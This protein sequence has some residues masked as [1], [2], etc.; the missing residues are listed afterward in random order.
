M[1]SGHTIAVEHLFRLLAEQTTEVALLLLD[2]EGRIR[3][4]SPGA[5][6]IFGYSA[7]Q[8]IGEHVSKLFTPED[9][10]SGVPEHEIAV[11]MSGDAAEDDRWMARAEGARFWASGVLVALRDE[12]GEVVGF[13][14][15]LRNRT[16][17][18]EHLDTLKNR[19]QAASD[20]SRRKDVFISTLVHEL[21]APLAPMTIAVELLR[22][23]QTLPAELEGPIGVLQRQIHEMR[24][25]IEKMLE[26]S[27]VQ[28]GKLRLETERLA[29]QDVVRQA[30]EGMLVIARQKNQR[31]DVVLSGTPIMIEVD[32][33]RMR[34]VFVNLF[35]NAIRY[36]PE[37]GRIW[38]SDGI[39]GDEAVLHVRDTG[40]GIPPEMLPRIFDLFTQAEPSHT[41]KYTG[42]GLG[43]GLA[44]VKE[45]VTLHGGSVQVRSEGPGKGS[46]F[47]VRLP[48]AQ[49]ERHGTLG[50]ATRPM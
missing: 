29:L 30:L 7:R 18:T 19:V 17:W 48:L 8:V 31:L 44:L 47:L 39:E 36:T 6:H 3:W 42:R 49:S 25:L 16:D 26:A 41:G 50:E 13:G 43:I 27:R 23:N 34:Q 32:P 2:R 14:K 4:W 38:V 22:Q 21:R 10:A 12:H 33:V 15:L 35:Q 11:A 46:E 5:Q 40:M 24:T 1:A 28:I 20:D 45:I 37:G 9:I